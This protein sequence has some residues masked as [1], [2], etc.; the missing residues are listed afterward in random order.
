[1]AD[2][3]Y[4]E[5]QFPA[6]CYADKINLIRYLYKGMM[7][8]PVYKG[9]PSYW[10]SILETRNEQWEPIETDEIMTVLSTLKEMREMP[11][12]YIRNVTICMVQSIIRIQFNC[13]GTQ[14]VSAE[15]YKKFLE[16]NLGVCQI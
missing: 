2:R 9:L 15:N 6:V 14:L 10:K 3:A 13:D 16:E 4:I 12:Y 8:S 7:D 5:R 1:M 11:E